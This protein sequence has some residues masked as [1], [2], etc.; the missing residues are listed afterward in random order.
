MVGVRIV[1]VLEGAAVVVVAVVPVELLG[2]PEGETGVSVELSVVLVVA[3]VVP[4]EGGSGL[5]VVGVGFG[6]GVVGFTV[7]AAEQVT[8]R[9]VSSAAK[10]WLT[11]AGAG[12]TEQFAH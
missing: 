1:V 6:A 10:V 12:F 7:T 3:T 2:P 4:T 9:H 8:L 11:Q 5:A